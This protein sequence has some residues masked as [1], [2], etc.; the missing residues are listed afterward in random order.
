VSADCTRA[1]GRTA[2]DN[3]NENGYHLRMQSNTSNNPES[4]QESGEKVSSQG[5]RVISQQLLG[6]R[7]ELIIE[8]E[9]RD[10]RLRLTQNGKLILTA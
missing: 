6:A 10:Y 1:I 3:S 9:G 8:H 5:G 4:K 7:G 2:F